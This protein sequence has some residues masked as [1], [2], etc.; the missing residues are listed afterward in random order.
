MDRE[1]PFGASVPAEG[2]DY[3]NQVGR[4]QH[5]LKELFA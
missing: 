5:E 2:C 3:E 1:E 4:L